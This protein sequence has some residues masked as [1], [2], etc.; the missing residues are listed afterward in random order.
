[1]PKNQIF[2]NPIFRYNNSLG[3]SPKPNSL[4]L[5]FGFTLVE[6]LVVIAIIGV[7]IA[8]LLPAVQAARESARRMTCTNNLKQIGL[9]VHNFHDTRQGL[10]PITIFTDKGS[11]FAYLY[12]YIE[13]QALYSRLAD[14]SNGL[15]Y[16]PNNYAGDNWTVDV[17]TTEE[18]NN[19]GKVATFLCPSRHSPGQGFA[20]R[21]ASAGGSA[22]EQCGPRSDYVTVVTQN[23]APTTISNW[24]QFIYLSQTAGSTVSDF[25]G[26]LRV[27][28]PSFRN[29]KTGTSPNDRSDL[30]S[31]ECRD[32]FSW[33][34]DGTTN[35]IVIGEKFIPKF[36]V[37]SDLVSH[38]RWDGG[39]LGQWPPDQVFN[40]GRY[41]HQNYRCL[42]ANPSDPG[43]ALNQR[44]ADH[45]GHYGFGSQ[46]V[47]IVH[48]LV[49]DGS[50]HGIN[51][52]TSTTVLW[53]LARVNDGNVVSIR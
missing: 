22:R 49:G 20:R 46:H 1:L 48:F 29:G 36:A 30:I 51:G 45:W 27:A 15:L 32:A 7:L 14:A 11:V 18:Q 17:L 2:K 47:G 23:V 16:L 33:W 28:I 43:I 53:N 10:P 6:L 50:V 40:I 19:I 5:F 26:P 24:S 8:L 39:Y 37:G 44:P 35:Q 31:W 41:I 42:V 25:N 9:G 13:Q 3:R 12:P 34:S 21:D 4:G 52:T 38:K